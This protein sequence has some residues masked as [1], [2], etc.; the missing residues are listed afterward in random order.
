MARPVWN[1]ATAY[2]PETLG[3]TALCGVCATPHC[4]K[5]K[6]AEFCSKACLEVGWPLHKKQCKKMAAAAARK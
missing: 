2:D 5:C 6:R 4:S 3:L 1:A